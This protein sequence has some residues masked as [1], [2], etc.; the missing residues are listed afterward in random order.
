[1]SRASQPPQDLAAERGVLGGILIHG[2]EVLAQVADQ[3]KPGDLYDRRHGFIYEA[4]LALYERNQPVDEITLTS[5]LADEGRLEAVGGPAYLA[6]LAD[7]MLAPAHVEHY[8]AQVREKAEARAFIAAAY[9]GIELV[10]KANGDLSEVLEQ[11]EAGIFAANKRG[12]AGG[13]A[14]LGQGLKALLEEMGTRKKPGIPTGFPSLD[15]L[16]LGLHP[17]DL[18]VVAGRP[19]MGKSAFAVQVA[20]NIAA[21]GMP[22][23]VFSL[24][25]SREQL[26]QRLLAGEAGVA[27]QK[28]RAQ[29]LY[30]EHWSLITKAAEVLHALPL[31]IDDSP[32]LSVL[33]IRSR[34]RRVAAKGRLGLVVVDYLQLARAPK[35]KEAKREEEVAEVSRSLKALAKELHC[36]VMALSQLNRKVEERSDKD[37]RPRLSDLRESGAIE[38]DADLIAFIYR[39]GVY[40]KDKSDQSAEIIVEKQRNGPTDTA[41]LLFEGPYV[42]FTE[43]SHG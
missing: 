41:H 4:M 28:I 12:S 32:A 34:A 10:Q 29:Q 38:Q 27:F 30:G 21:D 11:A 39:P 15:R 7:I 14:P 31:L 17:G 25:M 37:K 18:A 20:R 5:R 36:P 22:V 43:G 9:K 23:V 33:Q 3:L 16:T 24:E 13:P 26:Q 35:A 42:R 19:G 40:T 1:M 6:E 2:D 8:A